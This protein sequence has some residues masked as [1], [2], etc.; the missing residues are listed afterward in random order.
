MGEQRKCFVIDERG[1]PEQRDIVIGMSNDSEVEIK[2]GLK[3]GEKVALN[4]RVILGEK[5]GL[6]PA[7]GGKQR[8]EDEGGTQ[9]KGGKGTGKKGKEGAPPIKEGGPAPKGGPGPGARLHRPAP[10]ERELTTKTLFVSAGL[11]PVGRRL[12]G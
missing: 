7:G 1:R 4:P 11:A 3:P 12:A 2:Q 9:K 5:S 6:K 10:L 8:G